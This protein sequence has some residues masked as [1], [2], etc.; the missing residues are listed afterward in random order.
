LVVVIMLGVAACTYRMQPPQHQPCPTAPTAGTASGIG[1]IGMSL[2]QR[3]RGDG[4]AELFVDRVVP[5]GPAATAGIHPGDRI[6]TIDGTPTQGMSIAEA[7][8]RLRGP[9]DAA[10]ALQIAT[11]DRIRDVNIVRVAPSELWSGAASTTRRPSGAS[12]RVRPSD[13][14]PAE[15]VTA[16]PCRH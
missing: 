3:V 9:T 11:D 12:E 1:I 13:V 15:Q 5:D 16:P 4:D 14:A 6:L 7:A 8:R 10:I 2:D